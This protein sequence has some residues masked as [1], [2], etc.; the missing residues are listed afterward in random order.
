MRRNLVI[1]FILIAFFSV[2][3]STIASLIIYQRALDSATE[4]QTEA[5]AKSLVNIIQNAQAGIKRLPECQAP[6]ANVIACQR[7]FLVLLKRVANTGVDLIAVNQAGIKVAGNLPSALSNVN[8]EP[9]NLGQP[10]TGTAGSLVYAFVPLNSEIYQPQ[11]SSLTAAVLMTAPFSPIKSKTLFFLVF[12]L[13]VITIASIVGL[14][15]A[16]RFTQPLKRAV[17]ATN[18][19]ATGNL[20][21]KLEVNKGQPKEF[22]LLSN[23]INELATSLKNAK[24]LDRAFFMSIS[25]ELRT[26][27]TSIAGYAEAIV[28]NAISP[29]EAALIIKEQALKLN[30]MVQ[31][32]LDLGKL[33]TRQLTLNLKKVP[34]IEIIS[35]TLLTV[36]PLFERANL[37]LKLSNS[38]PEDIEVITDADRLKQILVN[39]LEN[40]Y[41]FAFNEVSINIS[42]EDDL[43]TISVSD[44][45]PGIKAEQKDRIFSRYYS[46]N[47]VTQRQAGTGLG[48]AIVK[49][50]CNLLG[51]KIEVITN[52]I[53]SDNHKT[54]F[55]VMIPST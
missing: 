38:I 41:K 51:Y 42:K 13:I 35:S 4:S 8:L 53:A 14:Y 6:N 32:I 24:E 12:G 33:E 49:E 26:P 50:L 47:A 10:V 39:L 34:F 22:Q 23:S 20:D 11:D 28:D 29:N 27:L 21:T 5:I 2:L 46:H 25:H 9:L 31:D 44:D 43:I 18:A 36:K 37:N 15:L 1:S 55:K 40:G 52:N 19:L 7:R 45:G 30:R 17:E 54:T 16:A 48:L 3:I